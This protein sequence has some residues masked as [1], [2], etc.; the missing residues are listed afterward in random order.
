MPSKVEALGI[1][2]LLLPGFL[3]S[4]LVRLISVRAKQTEFDKVVE[5]LLFS[6]VLYLGVGW[7]FGN[8]LPIS[9]IEQEKNGGPVFTFLLNFRYLSWLSAGSVLC[10][11]AYGATVNHNWFHRLLRTVRLTEKTSRLS[12]W[13]DT[14]QDIQS[15]YLLLEL[16]DQRRVLGYLRYYSD[17]V[18]EASIFLEDAAWLDQDGNQFPIEGPGILL[19]KEAGI[20]S[21]SFLDP[22]IRDDQ[23][24]Q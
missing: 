23:S 24:G 19:T 12:V 18:E 3:C 8:T 1:L 9:W 10:A 13:N 21:I 5:A 16:G 17:D 20:V 7:A 4:F 22:I 15:R 14:L 2:L 11:F 6:T